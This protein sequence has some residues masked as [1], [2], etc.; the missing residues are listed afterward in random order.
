MWTLSRIAPS[1][2]ARLAMALFRLVPRHRSPDL[3]LALLERGERVDFS[4]EGRRLAV[5]R[6]GRGPTALLVHG[7]GSRGVR[8]GSFVAPLHAAGFSVVAFD[9]PGH[10]AS[11]GRLSSLPQFIAAVREIGDRLGPIEVIVAH[12][13]GGAA[14]TLAMHRGLPVRRAVFLAPSADPAGYMDRFAS[15][16]GLPPG[17]VDRIKAG[18]ERRF[19]MAWDEFDVISAARKMSAPLLVFHDRD[20]RD[21]HWSDGEAIS[22]A[23]PGARLV[24]TSGLGHRRIVHDPAVVSSAVEFLTAGRNATRVSGRA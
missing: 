20:D 18:V 11:D 4:L 3:D 10:G 5:W 24:L 23:W 9:A 22:K 16:L 1:A 12:S 17:V 7:W 19:G 8:L 14:S 21:V 15:L 13:M 2:A 6:W